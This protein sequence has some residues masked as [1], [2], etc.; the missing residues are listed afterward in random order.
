[1]L[2]AVGCGGGGMACRS[3]ASFVKGITKSPFLVV[4]SE[5]HLIIGKIVFWQRS[6]IKL[7]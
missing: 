7:F 4:G 6:I 3:H 2:S 1:M 5:C